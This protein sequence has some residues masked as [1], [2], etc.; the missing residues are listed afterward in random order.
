MSIVNYIHN[1]ASQLDSSNNGNEIVVAVLDTGVDPGTNGLN[2]TLNG[3]PKV[4]DIV[5]CTGGGDINTSTNV[6][7]VEESDENITFL[8]HTGKKITLEKSS[9]VIDFKIGSTLLENLLNPNRGPVQALDGFKNRIKNVIVDVITFKKGNNFQSYLMIGNLFEGYVEDY[10]INQKYYSI[11]HNEYRINFGVKYYDNGDITCLVFESGSHGTHVSG[12]IAANFPDN[13][14]KNGIAPNA[15]IVS[16]K[17]GDSRL[18]GL[19]TVEA[20][21]RAFNEIVDRDIHLAN[22]SFGEPVN[23]SGSGILIDV[24]NK[25]CKEHNIIFVTSAGNSGPGLMTVGAP[26][27]C[28]SSVISVGAY[29][30]NKMLTSM[31]FKNDNEFK[32]GMF[33]WSSRGPTNDGDAG[34]TI[35]APGGAITTVSDWCKLE[36]D[37]HNGTSMA[38]PYVCGCI[39]KILSSLDYIPYFYWVKQCLMDSAN[40]LDF[41]HHAIGAGLINTTGLYDMLYKNHEDNYGYNV[42]CEY[43]KCKG[44]GIILRNLK[45][46]DDVISVNINITPFFKGRSDRSFEKIMS[47]ELSENIADI[48]TSLDNFYVNKETS[49]FTVQIDTGN[50][51]DNVYGEIKLF[52]EDKEYSSIT[53]PVCIFVPEKILSVGKS[54]EHTEK[55]KPGIPHRKFIVPK[56][57]KI[58]L[59]IKELTNDI[60]VYVSVTQ[61]LPRVSYEKQSIR[62]FMVSAN[63]SKPIVLNTESNN[64]TEICITQHWGDQTIGSV[65]YECK[66]FKLPSVH[67]RLL[68]DDGLIKSFV[69][70]EDVD[71]TAKN[72]ITSVSSIVNPI[73]NKIKKY[74]DKRLEIKK[75]EE[76]FESDSDEENE[77][78]ILTLSYKIPKC[79]GIYRLNIS[80]NNDIYE[81]SLVRSGYIT[82]YKFNVPVVFGNHYD[83][84]VD[85][86]TIDSLTVTFI[87]TSKKYLESLTNTAI[88]FT[89][90]LDAS[91]DC[92]K[93]RRSCVER[94]G[95]ISKID[96][97]GMYYF[98]PD[99]DD[100]KFTSEFNNY[101]LNGN[102]L[103]QNV[104]ITKA[105]KQKL[106]NSK[107]DDDAPE[108]IKD[109]EEILSKINPKNINN[110]DKETT[111][112]VLNSIEKSDKIHYDEYTY[113]K[114]ILLRG[115]LS[116]D[117]R[118]SCTQ[119]LKKRKLDNKYPYFLLMH[120]D[121][122]G[123]QYLKCIED[124]ISKFSQYTEMDYYKL[125]I[126]KENNEK[127][128]TY[129]SYMISKCD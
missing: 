45:D 107:N 21:I 101:T 40:D 70:V 125:K 87:G 96:V 18:S 59:K 74:S 124:N 55:L 67:P 54:I 8:L 36:L 22:L 90:C 11:V 42:L 5:D 34:V 24:I 17:I 53:V 37:L 38:S 3:K 71:T 13:P 16:L 44:R 29:A 33:Q 32:S 120:Y 52:E 109:M 23:E 60:R 1:S 62:K 94:N 81:S 82:G 128:K 2:K 39:A 126:E 103:G 110:I 7:P 46:E 15:Q 115:L 112:N 57:D 65:T 104:Y 63:S 121:S 72:E 28:T 108:E 92:Y 50:I 102:I 58:S 49:V 27:T 127:V 12:I 73:S 98:R 99:I 48:V 26:A 93:S 123:K 129:L 88:I 113:P 118:K 64:L 66:T 100:I 41:D 85:V 95:Q 20:L 43:N 117:D 106:E 76:T 84:K 89:K 122:D 97:D 31:Y 119:V 69:E 35:A 10:K 79:R 77:L 91:I 4:I 14:E 56:G 61:F 105:G 114:T 68:M 6:N 83:M 86:K 78:N 25:Y 19:E 111:E 9:D 80:V 75:F 30:D 51:E 47:V 116:E